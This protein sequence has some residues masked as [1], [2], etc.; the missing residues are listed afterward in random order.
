LFE[1][2]GARDSTRMA[3]IGGRLASSPE[4]VRAELRGYAV[5]AG[6]TGLIATGRTA[7]AGA[8]MKEQAQRLPKGTMNES[9][10]QVLRGHAAGGF[11]GRAQVAG[12]TP[13]AGVTY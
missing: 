3:R 4:E 9:V 2:V 11:D 12:V 10:F 8:F 7:E 13:V 5:L 6:A 1:A